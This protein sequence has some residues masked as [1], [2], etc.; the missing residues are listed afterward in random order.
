MTLPCFPNLHPAAPPPLVLLPSRCT[1][2]G[3]QK[4]FNESSLET[5]PRT[6]ESFHYGHPLYQ[7]ALLQVRGGGA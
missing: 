1:P 5:V 4:A 2:P 7:Y 3:A 6:A